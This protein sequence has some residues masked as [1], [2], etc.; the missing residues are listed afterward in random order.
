M[1]IIYSMIGAIIGTIIGELG[2]VV[3][4]RLIQMRRTTKK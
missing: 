1:T 2:I 4:I 3:A